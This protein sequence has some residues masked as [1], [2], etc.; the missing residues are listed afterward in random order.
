[1]FTRNMKGLIKTTAYG[2]KSHAFFFKKNARRSRQKVGNLLTEDDPSDP[3]GERTS[4]TPA[5]LKNFHKFYSTLYKPKEVYYCKLDK[6]LQHVKLRMNRA[7]K[8]ALTEKA[9]PEWIFTMDLPFLLP[10]PK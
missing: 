5:I 3:A 4:N 9:D 8:R 1:M 7:M 10:T 2:G 6:L